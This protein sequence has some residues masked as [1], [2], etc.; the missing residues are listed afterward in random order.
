MTFG[1]SL[2]PQIARM[3]TDFLNCFSMT[4][5]HASFAGSAA[6]REIGGEEQVVRIPGCKYL[7]L[8]IS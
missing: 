8:G 5:R 4:P 7:T 2:L 6:V 1:Y 3:Y